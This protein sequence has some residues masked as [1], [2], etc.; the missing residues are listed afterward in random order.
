MERVRFRR[1]AETGASVG[2]FYCAAM[3]TSLYRIAMSATLF[4][5]VMHG[6]GLW[7]VP[8]SE[9][10]VSIFLSNVCVNFIG[11]VISLMTTQEYAAVYAATFSLFTSALNGNIPFPYWMRVLSY[12][13][14]SSQHLWLGAHEF[15]TDFSDPPYDRIGYDRDATPAQNLGILVAM[16]AIYFFIAWAMLAW[17]MRQ[18]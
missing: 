10:W 8:Y 16:A 17:Q 13:F 9:F 11:G 2:A 14:W 12:A 5:S 7:A 6:L 1:E 18:K 15:V 3:L 4:S